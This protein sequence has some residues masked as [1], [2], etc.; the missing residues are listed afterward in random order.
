M[1]NLVEHNAALLVKEPRCQFSA[2]FSGESHWKAGHLCLEEI[3][4]K[5]NHDCHHWSEVVGQEQSQ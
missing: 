5:W 4:A 2:A 3:W 1:D